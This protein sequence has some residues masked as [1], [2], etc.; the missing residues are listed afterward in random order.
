MPRRGFGALLFSAMLVGGAAPA[1][2]A[3]TYRGDDP[4]SYECSSD[5][6][7]LN[8]F[9][10]AVGRSGGM[11]SAEPERSALT[12]AEQREKLSDADII[13]L[14]TGAALAATV[15]KRRR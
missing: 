5:F 11:S 2:A 10:C 13:E 15:V 1:G 3:E 4:D 9:F 14:A 12:M 6:K 7:I 8:R